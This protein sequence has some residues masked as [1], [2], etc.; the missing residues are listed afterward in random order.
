MAAPRTMPGGGLDLALDELLE[1]A[2]FMRVTQLGGA[3]QQFVVVGL[4]RRRGLAHPVD[5]VEVAAHLQRQ[6]GVLAEALEQGLV[7]L[8]GDA[9]VAGGRGRRG[10]AVGEVDGEL[11][12]IGVTAAPPAGGPAPGAAT[13]GRVNINLATLAELD[14]LP[15]IGP[16]LAQRIVDYRTAHGGFRSVDELRK[17]EGIGDAKFAEIKDRVTV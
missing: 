15:G 10:Q 14:T 12:L 13:G 17:V 16:A 5:P 11:L 7:D 1:G 6:L 8:A 2:L 3:P 4:D 9:I